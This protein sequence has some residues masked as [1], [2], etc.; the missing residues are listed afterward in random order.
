MLCHRGP[1]R[2]CQ[3][4]KGVRG[5]QGNDSPYCGLHGQELGTQTQ[6]WLVWIIS[7]GCGAKGL[8]DACPW[9]DESMGQ[10]S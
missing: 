9:G 6:E 1:H 7:A 3:E 10:G 2:G 5:K 4:A 8:S